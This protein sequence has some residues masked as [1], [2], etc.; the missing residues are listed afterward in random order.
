[1]SSPRSL[2]DSL[3]RFA[4]ENYQ[5]AVVPV[6]WAALGFLGRP[7]VEKSSLLSFIP[8]F[9]GPPEGRGTGTWEKS[10][11]TWLQNAVPQVLLSTSSESYLA[12]SHS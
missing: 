12:R 3:Y 5:R 1:M 11:Y 8:G 2:Y 9:G 6:P 10:V 7:A 4:F